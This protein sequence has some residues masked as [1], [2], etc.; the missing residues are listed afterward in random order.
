[1]PA[2]YCGDAQLPPINELDDEPGRALDSELLEGI[3]DER[4]DDEGIT[5]LMDDDEAPSQI[6][7]NVHSCHW[8]E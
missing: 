8:P 4:D 7:N 5:E 2:T 3:I 6:P 1:M